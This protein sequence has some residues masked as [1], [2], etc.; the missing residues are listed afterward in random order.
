MLDARFSFLVSRRPVEIAPSRLRP[1]P[2]GFLGPPT[3]LFV[4]TERYCFVCDAAA[5]AEVCPTCHRTTWVVSRDD[6]IHRTDQHPREITDKAQPAPVEVPEPT[7]APPPP[8]PPSGADLPDPAPE[9]RGSMPRAPGRWAPIAAVVVSGI[10]LLSVVAG[11]PGNAPDENEIETPTITAQTTTTVPAPGSSRGLWGPPLGTWV[12]GFDFS[13]RRP[14][15]LYG[16][17]ITGGVLNIG[18]ETQIVDSLP[19]G[20]LVGVDW[21]DGQVILIDADEGRP[22]EGVPLPTPGPQSTLP[23]LS[24]DGAKLALVDATGVPHV[25]TIAEGSVV[26]LGGSES[27][28]V[29]ALETLLWSPDGNVLALNAFQGGYYLWNLGTGEV[30]NNS[31]PGRAIAVSR[32][33]VAADGGEGLE[34]RDTSG[35]VLRRWDDLIPGGLDP[36]FAGGAFDP[37]QRYLAVWGRTGPEGDPDG[38][39][40]LSTIGT[41]REVL[42]TDP[43]QAF[44]WSGNG[45]ALYWLNKHGLQA[46]SA[47]PERASA[48]LVGNKDIEVVQRLRVYDPALSPLSHPALATT[49]LLENREGSMRL[50]T[51]DG[52]QSSDFEEDLATIT[53]AAITGYFFSVARGEDEQPVVLA[54]PTRQAP[55]SILGKLNTIQLPDGARITR[56]IA[57]TPAD[58]DGIFAAAELEATRWYLETDSGSILH[59]PEAELF[60]TA[61]EG[62]SLGLMGGTVF[63]VTPDGSAIQ[64]IP[65]GVGINTVLTAEDLD[66][67]RILA[68]GTVRRALF[69]LVEDTDGEVNLWQVPADSEL[70][71]T[72]LFP[73]AA[74]MTSW[75]WIVYTSPG[76][77]TSGWILTDPDTGPSGELLAARIDG[78]TGPVTVLMAAPLA[79]ESVCG[80]S[81]GGACV[82]AAL[83]GSPLGFSPDGSWLMVGGANGYVA[84]S[85]VGRGSVTFAD[86]APDEIVWVRF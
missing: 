10:V 6:E 53:P 63:H 12:G 67:D 16:P 3:T 2:W 41:T 22:L 59:G 79:L 40:V 27:P 52:L 65:V 58:S 44:A 33:Q 9:A 75:A 83:P 7:T 11:T 78:P 39:V 69:V 15:V 51:I 71:A 35:R 56:A 43:A 82:L 14:D 25:W 49:A 68:V 64:T 28:A 17:S 13:P 8:S 36:L 66:A 54:S 32:D 26:S 18:D 76:P 1:P 70:L 61:A 42:T 38:L 4:V 5:D 30:S 29:A 50:R 86:S 55:E 37:Q 45:S 23:V 62:S 81:A 57:M 34:L 84:H 20:R 19:D 72:P 47:D 80:A 77:A 21:G 85:T 48:T 74:T 24:P 73:P 46:W 31:M 60:T